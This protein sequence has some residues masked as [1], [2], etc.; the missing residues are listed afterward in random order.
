M[1]EVRS[2]LE[3]DI[4]EIY[5]PHEG[6]IGE[7]CIPLEGGEDKGHIPVEGHAGE[8]CIPLK[9][10]LVEIDRNFESRNLQERRKAL[11]AW[12]IDTT[13]IEVAS[14]ELFLDSSPKLG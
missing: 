7:V 10:G 11:I 5:P 2:T 1:R 4:R 8:V 13:K 14:F 12:E 9:D 6:G 3:G